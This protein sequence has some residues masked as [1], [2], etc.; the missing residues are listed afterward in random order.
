MIK[1]MK[2]VLVTVCGRAG[3]KGFRN[4]N[5]K[6][7]CGKPMVYYTLSTALLFSEKRPDLQVDICLNTDSPELAALV[8]MCYPEV[9]LLERPADLGGDRVPKMA[10]FQHSLTAMEARNGYL[11]DFHIDLDI[12]SPLRREND[13]ANAVA[14][15][16]AE[17]G[18]DLV[19]S[20]VPSRRNPYFNMAKLDEN[21][22]AK[23]IIENQNTSRQQA[24]ACF[25]INASLYVFSR[26]MLVDNEKSD[27]W[28]GKV[29]LYEMMDTGI[30][31][32]DS[33]EDYLLMEAI[34]S[35]LY[36]NDSSFAAI[37]NAIRE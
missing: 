34:A 21:G 2:H 9:T 14:M 16:E 26:D 5:L 7:F 15:F 33:E 19:M 22:F 4:K 11:Y 24:P 23:R 27:L 17:E 31:D 29:R 36:A 32:I 30:L 37:R 12:T 10:V 13:L 25:D 20:C 28:K 6:S 18:L 8:A 35:H 3:S 1:L